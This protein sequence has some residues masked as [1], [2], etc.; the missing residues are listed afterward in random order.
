MERV[1]DVKEANIN[2]LNV[3]LQLAYHHGVAIFRKLVGCHRSGPHQI[4]H[5]SRPEQVA[6]WLR[7]A[8]L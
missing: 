6:S 1:F 2:I 7:E 5:V 8:L 3:P 4:F